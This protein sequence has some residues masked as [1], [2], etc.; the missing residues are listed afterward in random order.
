MHMPVSLCELQPSA[1][2]LARVCFLCSCNRVYT[3]NHLR[4]VAA[5]II[6]LYKHRDGITGLKRVYATKLLSHFTARFEPIMEDSTTDATITAR[7]TSSSG[8]SSSAKDMAGSPDA[9][10]RV[11]RD[12]TSKVTQA[13]QNVGLSGSGSKAEEKTAAA[14][15][16]DAAPAGDMEEGEQPSVET[17]VVAAVNGVHSSFAQEAAAQSVEQ[18]QSW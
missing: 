18:Q 4:Y 14:Q 6:K 3:D 10:S 17:G 15:A 7:T 9:I 16:A 5:G 11:T 12:V 1:M 13:L 8:D 2:S